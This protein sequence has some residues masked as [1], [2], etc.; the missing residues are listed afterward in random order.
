MT[1]NKPKTVEDTLQG[2]E[3]KVGEASHVVSIG[4]LFKVACLSGITLA[5]MYINSNLNRIANHY[6]SQQQTQS[7]PQH[8]KGTSQYRRQPDVQVTTPDGKTKGM[9]Y[10]DFKVP[11]PKLDGS[12]EQS[13]PQ[14]KGGHV[15]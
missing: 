8:Q 13:K 12:Y 4:N 11:A 2:I 5:L 10:P 1:N 3:R 6:E 14:T 7:A 15:I 9:Y